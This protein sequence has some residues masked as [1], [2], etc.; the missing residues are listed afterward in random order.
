LLGLDG[1]I[2]FLA[3]GKPVDESHRLCLGVTQELVGKADL[4]LNSVCS[5]SSSPQ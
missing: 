5:N 3:V 2:G 4:D 1:W